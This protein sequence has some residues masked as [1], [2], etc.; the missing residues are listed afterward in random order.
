MLSIAIHALIITA[1]WLLMQK[2]KQKML[3]SS[4]SKRVEL[5]LQEFITPPPAPKPAQKKAQPPKKAH[6]KNKPIPQTPKPENKPI[7]KASKPKSEPAKPTT[8]PKTTP[9]QL[10]PAPQ[11][12]HPT[13][14]KPKEPEEK[15]YAKEEKSME[16]AEEKRVEKGSPLSKLAGALGA[17]SMPQPTPPSPSIDE[18]SDAVSNEEFKALYKDEFD[19]FTPDQ[20]RF[21]KNNLSRIQGITQHYLTLRGYPYIAARLNQQGMNIVEFYLH[22][23]GDISGLKVIQSSG[24]D[25]LDKNSLDTIKTA[26][27]DYPRPVETTKIR[28]YIYY[29][30]Y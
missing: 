19:R 20:K 17:P 5:S 2:E 13:P 16:R 3:T 7:R 9:S 15:S 22:P 12:P 24:T 4:T 21:I 25:V 29:R 6:S 23:N 14:K 1:I 11:K 18:I 8:K 30:L 26:Y 10:H 28:F 27:K